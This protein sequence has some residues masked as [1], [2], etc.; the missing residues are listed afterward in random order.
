MSGLVGRT[1]FSPTDLQSLPQRRH[2]KNINVIGGTFLVV[3]RETER[4]HLGEFPFKV[5]FC[6]YFAGHSF[7][8]LED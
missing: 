7:R 8:K 5:V 3:K 4:E 1:S 6:F 2:Y